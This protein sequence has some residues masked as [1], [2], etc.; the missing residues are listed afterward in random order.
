MAYNNMQVNIVKNRYSKRL[1]KAYRQ[2][3]NPAWPIQ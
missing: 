2:A 3:R 1:F